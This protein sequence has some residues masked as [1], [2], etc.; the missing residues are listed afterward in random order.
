MAF[1]TSLM[2]REASNRSVNESFGSILSCSQYRDISR[3]STVV[4]TIK[5]TVYAV[6]FVLAI[7]GN[8]TV[9]A[10]VFRRSSFKTTT[11]FF[12]ANLAISDIIMAVICMPTSMFSIA[13]KNISHSLL[14]GIAGILICKMLPFLQG[15]AIAVSILTMF[16]LAADRFL[17]IVFPFRKIITKRRAK[18]L[19]GGLWVL[20]V[21]FNAPLLYAMKLH[22]DGEV[23]LC[24]EDWEPHFDDDRASKDYTIVLFVFLYAIPLVLVIVFYSALLRELWRG[25]HLHH[26]KTVAC[27]ENQAVLRMIVTVIVTFAVCWLP[28]HVT[29]FI[30]LFT[31]DQLIKRCGLSPILVFIGWFMGHVNSA[32]NPIIY[33]IYNENFRNEFFK[34]LQGV[35][36]AILRK[37]PRIE[38]RPSLLKT[39]FTYYKTSSLYN[40]LKR[41]SRLDESV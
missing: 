12:I 32:L 27:K 14:Q 15:L 4:I 13:A 24:Y 19:I 33:F 31:D 28:V 5:I 21:I 26:N 8:A 40:A 6:A 23:R 2:S 30:A 29:V 38:E 18:A 41:N 11:N 20:G 17:A 7:I 9:L 10:I 25:K 16:T 34:L 1:N 39:R 3:D 37:K 36:R 35:M 22:E